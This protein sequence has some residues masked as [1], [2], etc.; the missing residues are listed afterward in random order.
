MKHHF[1]F[2]CLD[3]SLKWI[4]PNK[5]S[6]LELPSGWVFFLPMNNIHITMDNKSIDNILTNHKQNP[7]SLSSCAW[8]DPCLLLLIMHLL[9]W[10]T[11]V[12]VI[13]MLIWRKTCTKLSILCPLSFAKTTHWKLSLFLESHYPKAKN[14]VFSYFTQCEPLFHVVLFP[15]CCALKINQTASIFAKQWRMHL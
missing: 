13:K 7:Q 4:F 14:V 8:I 9:Y 1:E 12:A 3:I 5:G 15:L 6:I 2:P 11:C 10:S